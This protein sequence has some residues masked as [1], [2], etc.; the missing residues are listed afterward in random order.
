VP[1]RNAEGVTADP[2][3]GPSEFDPLAE[4]DHIIAD[5]TDER[6]HHVEE[7]AQLDVD[8]AR[9]LDD[10]A[11]IMDT[12]IRPAMNEAIARLTEDGGGGLIEERGNDLSHRPRVILWMS[13]AGAVVDPRQDRNP[14]LQLDADLGRKRIDIWEGDMW[15][16]QGVSRATAPWEL[17]DIS[18]ETVSTSIVGILRRAAGHD[19]STS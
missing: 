3:P 5:W 19:L 4:I 12:T 2:A 14:Y 13:L 17:G 9:F 11:K 6:H 1:T 15:E 7:E 18:R 10:F 8:R 16:K